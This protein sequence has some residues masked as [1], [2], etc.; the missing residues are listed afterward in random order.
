[1]KSAK[2]FLGTMVLLLLFGAVS[3]AQTLAQEAARLNPPPVNEQLLT[4]ILSELKQMRST[5][6]KTTVNQMR[7]QIVFDQYKVQQN[8]VDSQTRELDSLKTQLATSPFRGNMDA[9]VK[10]TEDRLAQTTDP[11][12][13]ENMERQLQSIKRNVEVQNQREKILKERQTALEYQ[14]PAERA[15]LDQLNAELEG[16]KA[17]INSMLNQ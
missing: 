4:A 9:L 5:L 6:A 15:K 3:F 16:I 13:R 10:Q 1:M 8:R 2:I 7:F 17:D 11:R 14:V 12:Q